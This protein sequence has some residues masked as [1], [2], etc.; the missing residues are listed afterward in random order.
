M[1]DHCKRHKNHCTGLAL[2]PSLS[3]HHLRLHLYPAS[4]V[5]HISM[6]EPY[7][8]PVSDDFTTSSLK[9]TVLF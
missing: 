7:G 8:L 9:A 4:S 1:F 5:F 2:D 3:C 6:E